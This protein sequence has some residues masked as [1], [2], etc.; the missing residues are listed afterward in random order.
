MIEPVIERGAGDA[1]PAVAHLGEIGK[2]QPARRVLLAK[3]DVAVG[4]VQR[5]PGA[6]APL[7]SA[8]DAGSDLGMAAPDLVED[9]DRP[10]TGG[11]LQ[12]RHHLA[13]ADLGQ[14][15]RPPVAARRLLLRRQPMV[16]LDAVCGS[17]AE[18]DLGR[19]DGCRLDLSG[20][21]V[22]PHLAVGDVA[23]RQG[24]VPHRREEPPPYPA[25]HDRQT[26][27]PFRRS[28]RRWI[29]DYG[30]ATPSLRLKPSGAFSSCL[31][32]GTVAYRAALGVF[33]RES[34]PVEWATTENNLGIVLQ[35]LG[36]LTGDA[37]PLAE[38]VDAYRGALEVRTRK[39]AP[40]EWAAT[41]NNLG[42]VLE[43]L[44]RAHPW[45]DQQ[46]AEQVPAK[47]AAA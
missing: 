24:A 33:T 44:D 46:P 13:V 4:A 7:Q 43:R 35:N 10:Q 3:D 12:H 34:A 11:I 39:Q 15:I 1:D 20:T 42:T 8:A 2:P 41:R 29:R 17:G 9:G 40:M 25:R 30:R 31:P 22:E 45:P 16:V 14:R 27:A 6:D 38:A 18:P 21:H 5:P 26:R 47:P 23:A 36:N 19:G 28:R 32:R 37:A